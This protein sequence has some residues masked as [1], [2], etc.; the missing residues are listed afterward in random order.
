MPIPCPLRVLSDILVRGVMLFGLGLCDP[1]RTS[2]KEFFMFRKK[3]ARD[4]VTQ[5]EA[6]EILNSTVGSLNTLR[7]RGVLDI[8]Y[9]KIR[10][11]IMYDRKDLYKWIDSKRVLP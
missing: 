10:S 2:W 6:A 4:L 3:E 11:R 1:Y 5:K 9:Y 7:S 8:P